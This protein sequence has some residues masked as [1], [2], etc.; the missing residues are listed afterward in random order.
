MAIDLLLEP[1]YLVLDATFL[2]WLTTSAFDTA[3]ID[4]SGTLN[5]VEVLLMKVATDL[6]KDSRVILDHR[7]G[8]TTEQKDR[9]LFAY[10][11][12]HLQPLDQR[13]TSIDALA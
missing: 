1:Q 10:V 5:E 2:E 6:R 13:S 3:D 9:S 7:S 11:R 8:H 12:T 4:R